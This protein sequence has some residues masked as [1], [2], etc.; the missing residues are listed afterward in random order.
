MGPLRSGREVW[1]SSRPRRYRLGALAALL[2][3]LGALTACGPELGPVWKLTSMAAPSLPETSDPSVVRIGAEYFV[4]GSDNHLRA[5]VTRTTDLNRPLSLFEKNLITTEAMPTEIPWSARYHQL[6]APTVA[7]FGSRWVMFFAADRRNPPQPENA[8]CIG[9]AWADSP[10]GPFVPE[11]APFTC[12]LM[13]VGGA[14]DPQLYREANGRTYLLA[15][16]SDTISPIHSIP[17]DANAS[18]SGPPV[19]ILPRQYPWE[20]HFIENPAM[21][22]DPVRGNWLLSYSAGKWFEAAYSTGIARCSTPLGPCTS[23]PSGPWVAS[24]SGRTG[25][26]GM[27]F[28][29]DPTG[30]PWVIL[31]S[32]P[33]GRETTVGGRSAT[34]LPLVLSPAVSAGPI[35]K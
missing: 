16:F 35:V 9:R 4:Y 12:G 30:Q 17:L 1:A 20:Y 31:S 27:S 11:A 15:A 13:Q 32:F 6:W 8:Q 18:A 21:T 26:G 23:D 19:M 29:D 7:Q 2:I 10:L 34:A 22:F 14:L 33:A 28:F 3:A 25:T 5:P 24:A